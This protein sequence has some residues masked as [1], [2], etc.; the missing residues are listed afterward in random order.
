[1]KISNRSFVK[2]LKRNKFI[3]GDFKKTV[4]EFL[5]RKDFAPIAALFNDADYF[6]STQDSLKILN[7]KNKLPKVFLYFDDL[8]FS[9]SQTGEFG[10]INDFNI[11][12]KS[13]IEKIPEF[14]ETMSLYW[15]NG[16]FEKR[17]F[18]HHDFHQDL[19]N[20]RYHNFYKNL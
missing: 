7:Q 20:T 8:N 14:A 5:K 2:N 18:I 15:K 3:Y 17:F 4:P 11:K 16:F 12:N 1:M 13:K 19:Y 6:F 9:S 10:A